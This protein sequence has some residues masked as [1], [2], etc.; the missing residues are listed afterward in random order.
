MDLIRLLK[1]AALNESF[2]VVLLS[3]TIAIDEN[4]RHENDLVLGSSCVSL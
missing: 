4:V 1:D 2:R 3:L